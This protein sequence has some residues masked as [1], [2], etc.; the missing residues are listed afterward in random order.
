MQH[1]KK[2]DLVWKSYGFLI[3]DRAR[4][5]LD[6]GEAGSETEAFEMAAFEL[7]L[8]RLEW[9]AFLEQLGFLLRSLSPGGAWLR[10]TGQVSEPIHCPSANAFIRAM[11]PRRDRPFEV[12]LDRAAGSVRIHQEGWY[13]A[14]ACPAREGVA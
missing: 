9:E 7:D 12:Y 2:P 5:Y 6:S 10:V 3:E 14:V 13:E 8:V 4:Q 1:L 11:L